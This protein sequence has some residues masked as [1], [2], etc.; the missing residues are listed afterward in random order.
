MMPA[1]SA[2]GRTPDGVIAMSVR[3]LAL[4]LCIAV[5]AAPQA[6]A[7]GDA[8]EVPTVLPM[9]GYGAFIGH[10]QSEAL[11]VAEKHIN[12]TGGIHGRPIHFVTYDSQSDPKVDIQLMTTVLAKHPPMVVDGGPAT[13]C[14][15]IAPLFA[16]GPVLWC[17]SPAFFP[18]RDS[19]TFATGVESRLGMQTTLRYL[20]SAGLRRIGIITAT[21]IAGQEADTAL[22]GLISDPSNRALTVVDAEHY[23]PTD[24]TVTAQLAKLKDAH[25]DVIVAW[26][27]GTPL[28]T[29]LRGI[30]D[31]GMTL[32]V[33]TSNAN[34]SSQQ[35]KQYARI[36]PATYMMYSLQWPAYKRMRG[37]PL[38]AAL[39]DYFHAMSA[40]GEVPDGNTAMIWDTVTLV[41]RALRNFDANVTP[42]QL[43][44]YILNL[45]DV[46]GA[47]GS[48]DFRLGNQRGLG[49]SDCIMV[50]WDAAHNNWQPIS[51]AGGG[52]D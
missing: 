30:K 12:D 46:Y 9:S 20:N 42:D 17:M 50:R 15:G 16:H 27:T 1:H 35:M 21:D 39:G 31:A 2:S 52:P 26:A 6:R 14:R 34:Q 44:A 5:L 43:R 40:A 18:D 36:L 47:S 7:A 32:P 19:F 22:A 49:L 28:A 24:L 37:G 45:H 3:A 38:K 11:A 4:V 8:V 29:V 10:S 48:F 41:A 23:A 33:V 13:V 51:G 25:P